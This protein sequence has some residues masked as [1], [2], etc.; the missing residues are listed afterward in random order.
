VS[1]NALHCLRLATKGTPFQ[2]RVWS[3]L[4]QIQPGATWNYRGLAVAIGQPKAIRAVGLANGADPIGVAVPCH[5]VIGSS[6]DS[7]GYGG[8][9]ARKRWLLAHEGLAQLSVEYRT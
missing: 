3:A 9:F 6:G 1:A 7:K 8:G 5:R 2:E 4:R